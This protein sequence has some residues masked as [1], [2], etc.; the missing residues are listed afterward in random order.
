MKRKY[1]INIKDESTGEII[2]DSK[3]FVLPDDVRY[4]YQHIS[5][6]VELMY[7]F[8]RKKEYALDRI[9]FSVT[10]PEILKEEFIAFERN[11]DFG[12]DDNNSPF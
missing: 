9:T 11:S 2:S 8:A 5:S 1:K 3:F 6:C 10:I 4:F 12:I 7:R